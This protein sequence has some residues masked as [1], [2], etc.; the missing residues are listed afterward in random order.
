MKPARNINLNLSPSERAHLRKNK[1]K[2]ADIPNYAID[3]LE[4]ILEVPFD[5]AREIYALADFQQI[6]SIGIRFAEDLIFLGYYS[7]AELQGKEGAQLT[8]EYEK[9]KGYRTDPCVEDQFRLAVHFSNTHDHS[10]T[11]WDFTAARK[12]YRMDIG[13]PTDRPELNWTEVI[14][15]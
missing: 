15:T 8:D 10:K 14:R 7:V 13:Y 9:K 3:E 4:V 2:I 11:W 6:P 1:V 12:Q 5:R